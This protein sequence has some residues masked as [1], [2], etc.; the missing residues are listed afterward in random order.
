MLISP[1][2]PERSR[3]TLERQEP[4]VRIHAQPHGRDPERRVRTRPFLNK[5]KAVMT[6]TTL[7]NEGDRCGTGALQ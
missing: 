5:Y 7:S 4:P 1:V 3:V 6:P 2:R